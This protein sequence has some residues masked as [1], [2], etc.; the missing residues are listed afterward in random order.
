MNIIL[1][2]IRNYKVIFFIFQCQGL[3]I[4]GRLLPQNLTQE[5]R[6]QLYVLYFIIYAWIYI[7]TLSTIFCY[8]YDFFPIMDN[9]E[10]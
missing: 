1:M 9:Y 8:T 5:V 4:E 3:A 6:S 10:D 7:A 2:Y